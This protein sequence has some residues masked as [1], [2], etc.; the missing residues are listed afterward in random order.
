MGI[1]VNS[2]G[3]EL[4]TEHAHRSRVACAACQL[5]RQPALA[6]AWIVVGEQM[7]GPRVPVIPQPGP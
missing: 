6:F 2:N 3:E 5:T 1:Q 7:C 4:C